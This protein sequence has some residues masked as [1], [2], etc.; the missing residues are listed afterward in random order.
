MTVVIKPAFTVEE[1]TEIFFSVERQLVTGESDEA[2][3]F[4]PEVIALHIGKDI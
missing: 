2:F 1:I 3:L 4:Q